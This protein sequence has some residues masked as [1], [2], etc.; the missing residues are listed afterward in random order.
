MPFSCAITM[1][2]QS[3]SAIMEPGDIFVP[4]GLVDLTSGRESTF[5]AE[6]GYGF[7]GQDPVWCPDL[8]A[9]L[10]N[11]GRSITERTFAR[12]VLA[13]GEEA[14]EPAEAVGWQA[15]GL[16]RTGTPAT[17]LA[18]ELELCYAVVGI[19]GGAASERGNALIAALGKHLPQERTCA[20]ATSM[21]GVRDRG[22]IGDDWRT[23]IGDRNGSNP[24]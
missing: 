19:V 20:C 4:D 6:R 11:A 17:Y 10:I 5:F 1:G 15:Q 7:I 13:V 21:Q 3:V 12:G 22:L 18:K 2:E 14:T 24:S 9:A 8:R 16:A 23:W